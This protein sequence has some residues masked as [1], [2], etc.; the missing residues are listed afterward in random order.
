MT[1]FIPTM[2]NPAGDEI[3]SPWEA[4]NQY[5][6]TREPRSMLK[7]TYRPMQRPV[8]KGPLY[9]LNVQCGV[10]VISHL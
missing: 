2:G 6:G 4:I 8:G 7:T 3:I 9:K 1:F 5:V 10:R